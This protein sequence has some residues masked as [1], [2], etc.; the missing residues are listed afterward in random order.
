M[1]NCWLQR[2][3]LGRCGRKRVMGREKLDDRR[4]LVRGSG[5]SEGTGL[6]GR[7][8]CGVRVGGGG[9]IESGFGG[10]GV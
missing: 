7:Q 5:K 9:G 3:S 4:V 10:R 2:R 8:R 1:R 6:G